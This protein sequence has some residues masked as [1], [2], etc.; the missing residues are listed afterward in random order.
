M[1]P[2]PWRILGALAGLSLGEGLWWATAS[3]LPEADL[4]RWVLRRSS[5]PLETAELNG[6]LLATPTT[7]DLAFYRGASPRDLR[8]HDGEVEV[9]ARVDEGGQLRVRLGAAT[10]S[11]GPQAP[12]PG[13]GPP[14]GGAPAHGPA[15]PAAAG[16]P[17]PLGAAGPAPAG[18]MSAGGVVLEPGRWDMQRGVSVL[19]DRARGVVSGTGLVCDPAAAPGPAVHLTLRARGG[20][21]EVLED[22]A[23]LTRCTGRWDVG[24]VVVSSGV[25]R[26]QVQRV[27]VRPADGPAFEDDFHGGLRG[28]A[29]RGAALALGLAVGA[30]RLGRRGLALAALPL[31]LIPALERQD[32]RAWMDQLR[33]LQVDEGYGPLLFAGLPAAA[34]VL[35]VASAALPLGRALALGALPLALA[36]AVIALGEG[37]AAPFG[38][39]LLVGLGPLWAALCWVN[40]HPVA[41]RP[42]WSYALLGGLLVQAELGARQSSLD[43]SWASTQGWER[44]REEFQELLEIRQHRSYPHSGFPVAPPPPDPSRRRIVALGGSS[45]GGAFQMDDLRLF[46]PTRLEEAI[47]QAG[48]TQPWEVVNQGVGGWNSLHV[49]LYVESQLDRLDADILALYLGHNDILT[50]T[51]APYKELYSRYQ[52]EGRG[53]GARAVSE[54]LSRSRLYFGFRFGVLAL[55]DRGGALAV[56]IEH[57]R[58]NLQAILDL[59]RERDMRVLLMTEGL[60]P[61]PLPMQPYAD[62][63]AEL[64]AKNGAIFINAAKLLYESGDPELF[65]DDCHLSVDGHRRLA[66]W[67]LEALRG[68]GWI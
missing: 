54:A 3:A 5:V 23:P 56:P 58:E 42:A 25:R 36:A 7:L 40:T 26:V 12:N 47:A 20:V 38:W 19:I 41:R 52:Q 64:A 43:N 2:N 6:P 13:A 14:Q 27:A 16:Q 48:S 15:G 51:P 1:R 46:W 8:F 61:D 24:D 28:W 53:G 62:M 33:L 29:A 45:T 10:L 32:M 35:A 60:N 67:A 11:A 31:L 66:A 55:R 44:A 50:L 34:A 17:S 63:Q 22:G 21:V 65:L 59:A 49:R 57:A 4:D 68:A 18:P 39:V 37:L 9:Q 30:A